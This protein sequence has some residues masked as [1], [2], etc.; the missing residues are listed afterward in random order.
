LNSSEYLDMKKPQRLVSNIWGSVHRVAF[1]WFR[2]F[3]E[4]KE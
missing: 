4:A 3:G 1:S 2:S